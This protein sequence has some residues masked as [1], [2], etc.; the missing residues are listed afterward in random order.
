ML[1][2]TNNTTLHIGTTVH[3]EIIYQDKLNDI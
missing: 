3:I 1:K 2:I